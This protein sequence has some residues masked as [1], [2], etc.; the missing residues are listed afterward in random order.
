MH[1][2]GFNRAALEKAHRR[3]GPHRATSRKAETTP[4]AT[5]KMSRP[6]PGRPTASPAVI[7]DASGSPRQP[8]I[9]TQKQD[10]QQIELPT[11][12]GED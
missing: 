7:G 10:L 9:E 11:R 5:S 8:Q 1:R 12:R 2:G 3:H 6:T 4:V